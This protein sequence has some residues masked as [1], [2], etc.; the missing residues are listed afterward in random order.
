MKAKRR[1]VNLDEFGWISCCVHYC[2]SFGMLKL[3]WHTKKIKSTV[4]ER[5]VE[6]MYKRKSCLLWVVKIVIRHRISIR[7]ETQW[8]KGLVGWVFSCTPSAAIHLLVGDCDA[9]TGCTKELHHSYET[10]SYSR[11]IPI[12]QNTEISYLT[13]KGTS[14]IYYYYETSYSSSPPPP[15]L[16]LLS[17][18]AEWK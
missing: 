17:A 11:N 12:I 7:K 10:S 4:G 9:Q 18:R 5:F 16:W 15:L 2:D 6:R 3:W 13:I 8:K 1:W 14:Q